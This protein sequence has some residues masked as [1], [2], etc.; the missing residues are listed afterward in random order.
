MTELGNLM[1][2]TAHCSISIQSTCKLLKILIG[3]NELTNEKLIEKLEYIEKRINDSDKLLDKYY[4]NN[5]T[6]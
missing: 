6:K 1:H 4:E 2:D 3:K 5:K